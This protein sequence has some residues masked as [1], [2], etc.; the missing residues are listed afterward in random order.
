MVSIALTFLLVRLVIQLVGYARLVI[1]PAETP[2][3]V[4]LIADVVEH[5]R[6]EI[7][8]GTLNRDDRE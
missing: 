4:P 5:A 2:T 6:H 7:A 3:A 8:S 1:H